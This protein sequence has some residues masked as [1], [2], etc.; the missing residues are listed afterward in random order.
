MARIKN[1]T[2]VLSATSSGEFVPVK[3]ISPSQRYRVLSVSLLPAATPQRLTGHVPKNEPLGLRQAH[4]PCQ[5]EFLRSRWLDAAAEP[6]APCS[7]ALL[8]LGV[9]RQRHLVPLRRA[10]LPP[11]R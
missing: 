8:V 2:L 11:M 7:K 1:R 6:L 4:L 3:I 5:R 9:R 10:A